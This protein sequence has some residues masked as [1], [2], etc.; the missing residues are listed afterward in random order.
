[1]RSEQSIGTPSDHTAFGLS[2]YLTVSGLSEVFW[3]VPN[4]VSGATVPSGA[5]C[6][7]PRRTSLRTTAFLLALLADVLLLYA[8]NSCSYAYLIV[9]LAVVACAELVLLLVEPPPL[10]VAQAASPKALTATKAIARAAVPEVLKLGPPSYGGR[11]G[12]VPSAPTGRERRPCR[13]SLASGR[14][15]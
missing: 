13:S 14:G 9:V 7:K 6:Q 1:M 5:N 12:R 8:S 2:V 3:N 4:S 11:A 15:Q 10:L